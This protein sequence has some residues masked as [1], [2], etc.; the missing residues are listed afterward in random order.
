MH[1]KLENFS[2]PRSLRRTPAQ[3]AEMTAS[4]LPMEGS[5]QVHL[6]READR[7]SRVRIL[8]NRPV[9]A[10]RMF[11]GG[12]V[13]RTLAFLPMLYQVC[14]VAQVCTA[15]RAMESAAGIAVGPVVQEARDQLVAMETMREHL[16]RIL[17]KWPLA[18][19]E[20][21]LRAPAVEV[22]ILAR[23]FTE[24]VTRGNN[25]L[26]PGGGHY[27]PRCEDM[28]E[29]LDQ[30]EALLEVHV[31]SMPVTE[32]RRIA[33]VDALAAWAEEGRTSAARLVARVPA[34]GW[35]DPGRGQIAALPELPFGELE[36][37]LAGPDAPDFVAQPTWQ[38][39]ACETSALTRRRGDPLVAEL[40]RAHG[41]GLLPRLAA[42]LVELAD[43]CLALRAGVNHGGGRGGGIMR[44]AAGVTGT[45]LAQVEAARGRLVHRVDLEKGRVRQYQ[46][47]APTEWNFHPQG[48]LMRSLTGLPGRDEP[49][50]RQQVG[51][52]IEAVDPCVSYRVEVH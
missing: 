41:N 33:D 17:L 29:V 39:V 44:H 49:Q 51:L 2:L 32:R 30:L 21:S 10:A 36:Q 8:S 45:G 46:I 26:A 7:V 9:H 4:L 12:S 16:G 22:C 15:V 47:L 18:L 43:L 48:A 40:M 13:D 34:L 1:Q 38:G 37:R 6:Y 5:L 28:A 23:R 27:R 52:L 14:A 20:A 19:G 24:A 11:Q 42:C 25:L 50:L 31:F 35:H 3:E